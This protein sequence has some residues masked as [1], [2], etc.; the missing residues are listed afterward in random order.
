M[1]WKA[2]I[3]HPTNN[4]HSQRGNFARVS[5]NVDETNISSESLIKATHKN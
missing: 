1:I 5:V 3:P 2:P 4:I